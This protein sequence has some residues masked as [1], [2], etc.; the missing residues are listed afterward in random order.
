M[1]PNAVRYVSGL[2]NKP[3]HDGERFREICQLRRRHIFCNFATSTARFQRTRS[4]AKNFS[5]SSGVPP[6]GSEPTARNFSMTSG[7]R[8]IALVSLLSFVTISR[9]VLAGTDSAFHELA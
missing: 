7:F 1:S 3:G 9:G 6:T 8:K 5:T 4:S 2:Y